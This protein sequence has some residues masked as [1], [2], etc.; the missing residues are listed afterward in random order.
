MPKKFN[1]KN[2]NKY[3]KITFNDINNKKT[4]KKYI[5][6]P[7]VNHKFP[8]VPLKQCLHLKDGIS[9]DTWIFC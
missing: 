6:F 5:S 7:P 8:I 2:K 1:K 4:I 3:K 9:E